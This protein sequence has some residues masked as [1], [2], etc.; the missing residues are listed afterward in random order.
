MFK[1][2]CRKLAI[3]C[4]TLA[5]L[6]SS[7][8]LFVVFLVAKRAGDH[9]LTNLGSHPLILQGHTGAIKCLE[10]S[11]DSQILAS[12]STD[13][14]IKLW[15]VANGKQLHRLPDKYAYSMCFINSDAS[16]I[17]GGDNNIIWEWDIGLGKVINSIPT[18]S[19]GIHSIA[20]SPDEKQCAITSWN[21]NTVIV[22]DLRS[23]HNVLLLQGHT[24]IVNAVAYTADGMYLVTASDDQS[25]RIWDSNSGQ[26]LA[27]MRGHKVPVNYIV[28]LSCGA[29]VASGDSDGVIILWEFPTRKKK[30]ILNSHTGDLRALACS[31]D[32]N[33]LASAHGGGAKYP[34]T[35]IIWDAKSGE[36]L[37]S[38]MPHGTAMSA[39]AFSPD[40]DLLATGGV[41]GAVRVSKLSLLLPKEER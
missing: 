8:A 21:A 6:V 2:S 38:I 15:K 1:L 9:F 19:S 39:I 16:L 13:P 14:M 20:V 31:A 33:Y 25:L 36:T 29:F 7:L 17:L 24:D 10:F 41:D 11:Q 37:I 27:V 32:G 23:K 4:I 30:A 28:M 12:A 22:Y 5:I 35:L 3:P 40:G 18:S 34:G 26:E